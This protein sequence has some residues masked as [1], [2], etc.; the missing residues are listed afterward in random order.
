MLSKIHSWC[1]MDLK[2]FHFIDV[3]CDYKITLF[4][5]FHIDDIWG[6]FGLGE[7]MGSWCSVI[8]SYFV[9]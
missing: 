8:L 4:I 7:I 5:H 1:S 6:F 3:W 2:L 9:I